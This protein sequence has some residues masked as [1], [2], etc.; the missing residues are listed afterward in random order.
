VYKKA[1]KFK[2]DQIE[3]I[4][5][6]IDYAKEKVLK[7]GKKDARLLLG[8]LLV[9]W[10]SAWFVM[11]FVKGT[12][13]VLNLSMCL[14]VSLVIYKLVLRQEYFSVI[15]LASILILVTNGMHSIMIWHY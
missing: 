9:C 15:H 3:V 8:V 11:G 2:S 1:I 7:I 13:S 6:S 12:A 10:L 5:L 4:A 14:P